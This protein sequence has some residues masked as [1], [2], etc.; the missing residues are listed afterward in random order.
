MPTLDTAIY[1]KLEDKGVVEVGYRVD[2]IAYNSNNE[3]L[4]ITGWC[5]R[6]GR[7]TINHKVLW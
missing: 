5:G 1:A 6:K 3:L 4:C 2:E 7:S